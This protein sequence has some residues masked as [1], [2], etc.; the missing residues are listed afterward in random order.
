MTLVCLTNVAL[1]TSIH[2]TSTTHTHRYSMRSVIDSLCLEYG[3]TLDGR[4][5][6]AARWLTKERLVPVY[7]NPTCILILTASLRRY[8][9][10]AFN[11]FA[12]DQLQ[13]HPEIQAF[14]ST[15][16]GKK[17]LLDCQRIS[18]RMSQEYDIM[19]HL[20]GMFADE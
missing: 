3:S 4:M 5:Q 17:S 7:V 11:Y 14:L 8:E 15:N 2:S 9:C 16:K 10:I 13:H 12:L 6:A 19:S 18:E 1:G 20:K